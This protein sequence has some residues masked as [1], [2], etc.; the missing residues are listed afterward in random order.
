MFFLLDYFNWHAHGEPYIFTLEPIDNGDISGKVETNPTICNLF[1]DMVL[2]ATGFHNT[3]NAD[4][5]VDEQ[6][7]A[8]AQS[9]YD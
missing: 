4:F 3:S 6:P 9:F 5:G 7:N 1:R 8:G 2:D